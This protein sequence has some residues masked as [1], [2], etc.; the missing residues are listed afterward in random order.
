[1]SIQIPKDSDFSVLRDVVPRMWWNLYQGCLQVGFD[2]TQA[3]NLVQTYILGTTSGG[4]RPP[5]REG[6]P[7]DTSFE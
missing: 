4:I 1:M 5:D 2:K 6:P 3:F 7:E